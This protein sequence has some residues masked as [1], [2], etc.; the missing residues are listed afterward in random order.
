MTSDTKV[1]DDDAMRIFISLDLVSLLE[2][3]GLRR[4]CLNKDFLNEI[5]A[6]MR[7]QWTLT[8][9]V[10]P[11]RGDCLHEVFACT[12]WL[13]DTQLVMS[14]RAVVSAPAPSPP[15]PSFWCVRPAVVSAS[16]Q[17]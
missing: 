16:P 15:I 4:C 5:W 6:R 13:L 7:G 2:H 3:W 17:F 8:Q 10:M 14:A 12:R 1:H 11:A 9:S